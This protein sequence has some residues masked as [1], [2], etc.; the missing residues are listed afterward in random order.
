[1]K[2]VI[3]ALASTFLVCFAFAAPAV[4]APN[5]VANASASA[6][7]KADAKRDLKVEHQIKDLHA[8]LKI[9][10]AEETQWAAV[11]NTMRDNAKQI[12]SVIDKRESSHDGATAIDDLNAYGEVAQAHADGVKKLATAFAPLY[13][14]MSDDQKKLADDVFAH[15]RHGKK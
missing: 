5:I 7:A 15:R 6:M 13:A 11:A 12:D 1:M 3:A 2:T 4:A 9:T 10:E 8:K 14:S